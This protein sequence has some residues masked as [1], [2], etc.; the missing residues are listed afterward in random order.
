MPK[1]KQHSLLSASSAERWLNCPGSVDLTKDLP[2]TTNESAE[3]GSLAHEIA[4]LK[5]RKKLIEG[6]GPK[7][8]TARMNKFKKDPLYQEE[9]QA[10]TDTYVDHIAEIAYNLPGTPMVTA[11]HQVD[12]S[13]IVP[14]GFGTA[15]CI[16]TYGN[17]LYIFDF[18][19]GRGIPVSAKD[20]PQLRLYAY[21]AVMAYQLLCDIKTIHMTIVQPRN[22]GINSETV[23]RDELID[24]AVFK[25]RPIAQKAAEGVEE[26]HNGPWCRWCK[27]A[28]FCREHALSTVE[29]VE[30]FEMKL[31]P[32]LTPEEFSALL[33][34]LDPLIKYANT[35]KEYAQSALLKGEIIPGWKLV[36]GKS[37]R[38]W[39]N[40]EKAFT[41]IQAAGINGALLYERK[42]V[43][44][45][46]LEKILGSKLFG[47]VA[48]S[49]AVKS[50][51]KPTL[52]PENDPR[53]AY[54]LRPSAE[55]DFKTKQ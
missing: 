42:P 19:Y 23:T 11:E 8:F 53:E 10:H 20:N 35:A 28:P 43:T 38:I 4:E 44:P 36:S 40:Q 48:S 37:N 26:Y 46:G 50:P 3:E 15:D 21:G 39:A 16:M 31:P 49:Y 9:M 47:E 54:I 45:P 18:K 29:A 2:D 34:K 17:D 52:A 51:G 27:A 14:G 41:A 22:G 33:Y 13:D 55:D 30:D 25:V 5:L 1:P 32:E 7:A 6:I 24:W 12:F